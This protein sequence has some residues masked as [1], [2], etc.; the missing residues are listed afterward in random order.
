[1]NGLF[2]MLWLV[3]LAA[4]TPEQRTLR[5]RIAA[6]ARWS[7]EDPRPT[8]IRGQDGLTAR[9]EREIR[10]EFPDLPDREVARRVECARRA[11]FSRLAYASAKARSRRKRGPS[12]GGGEAA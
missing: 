3:I 12:G 8:A 7:R 4:L 2:L 5:A 11:H 1:L 9:F 10:D 6:N